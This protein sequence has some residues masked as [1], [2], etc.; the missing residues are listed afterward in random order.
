MKAWIETRKRAKVRHGAI[1]KVKSF[2]KAVTGPKASE[3]VFA[4]RMSICRECEHLK[5]ANEKLYCGACGCGR[6]RIAE[7]SKKLRFANLECPKGKWSTDN[8]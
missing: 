2:V 7:L 1:S 3:E 8:G 4:A 6:W 5:T